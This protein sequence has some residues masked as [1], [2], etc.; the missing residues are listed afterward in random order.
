MMALKKMFVKRALKK[1]VA[2]VVKKMNRLTR[3]MESG[4]KRLEKRVPIKVTIR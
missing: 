3:D 2:G 1:K 4:L